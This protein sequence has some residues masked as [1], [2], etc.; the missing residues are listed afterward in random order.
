LGVALA[1]G[2]GESLSKN[3]F[4]HA[5][6]QVQ[7]D[8]GRSTYKL[9]ILLFLLFLPQF[10]A[11]YFRIRVSECAA[12]W[13]NFIHPPSKAHDSVEHAQCFCLS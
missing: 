6:L 13:M 2:I 4:L 8:S 10:F 7:G 12:V 1:G 5:I 3:G 11:F 9:G